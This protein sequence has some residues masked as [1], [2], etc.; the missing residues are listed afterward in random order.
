MMSIDDTTLREEIIRVGTIISQ[1]KTLLIC[2][3]C[4]ADS[5]HEVSPEFIAGQLNPSQRYLQLCTNSGRAGAG[6]AVLT[7]SSSYDITIQIGTYRTNYIT[8]AK[9]TTYDF[10]RSHYHTVE[11]GIVGVDSGTLW[12]IDPYCLGLH[13]QFDIEYINEHLYDRSL[14]LKTDDGQNAGIAFQSGHGDGTYVVSVDM[15]NHSGEIIRISV[16]TP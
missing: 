4:F 3:P 16:C 10:D 7:Q 12:I 9:S 11:V 8:S 2:D 5:Q 15:D 6:I 13:S 1:S 14:I